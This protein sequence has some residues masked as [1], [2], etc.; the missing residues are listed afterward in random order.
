MELQTYEK[1]NLWSVVK[2]KWM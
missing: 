2:I 1:K